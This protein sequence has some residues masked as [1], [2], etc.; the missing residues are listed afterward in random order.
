MASCQPR[1]NL[2]YS[3]GYSAEGLT[4]G[5]G[6]PANVSYRPILPIANGS[7][8]N[9]TYS[10]PR[11]SVAPAPSASA[12]YQPVVSAVPASVRYPPSI[13]VAPASIYQSNHPVAS[14]NSQGPQVTSSNYQSVMPAAPASGYSRYPPPISAPSSAIRPPIHQPSYAPAPLVIRIRTPLSRP[15][16]IPVAPAPAVPVSNQP[17][18][19]DPRADL[20]NI[21]GMLAQVE[22]F[23]YCQKNQEAFHL[24][25]QLKISLQR[26]AVNNS[27]APS[28]NG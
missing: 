15:P 19:R 10:T 12:S 18:G 28:Q 17:T 13:S 3:T 2:G 26:G 24:A 23:A 4:A 9:F 14:S 11:Y 1:S 7:A 5:A 6:P 27:Q 21:L 16:S 20:A 25:N 8:S 22:L